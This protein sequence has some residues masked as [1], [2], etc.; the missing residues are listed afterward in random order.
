MPKKIRHILGLTGYYHKFI[1]AY[2]ALAWHLM[3]LAHMTIPFIWTD[4][5]KASFKTV[6]GAVMKNPILVCPDTNKSYTL[7]I[8]VAK[9]AWSAML[10]QALTAVTGGKAL[11]YQHPYYW[12]KWFIQ[13]VQLNWAALTKEAYLIYMVV[14]DDLSNWLMLLTP[15]GVTVYL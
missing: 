8:E 12:L 13:G 4:H 5:C 2:G 10:T 14:K 3:P 15:Y 6:K 1:P 11:G 9:Y 7:F